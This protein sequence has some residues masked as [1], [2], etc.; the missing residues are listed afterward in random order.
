MGN[1][2]THAVLFAQLYTPDGVCHGLHLFL[3][4]LRDPHD[5]KPL[6]GVIVGDMGTKLG[7]NGYAHGCV[8]YICQDCHMHGSIIVVRTY[9]QSCLGY[10]NLSYP[11]T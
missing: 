1:L 2:A 7:Q 8:L 11:E 5:L 10:L 3:V 4:P 6:P 9:I